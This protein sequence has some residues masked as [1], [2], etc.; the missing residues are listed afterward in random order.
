MSQ[1]QDKKARKEVNLKRA[2]R[3]AVELAVRDERRRILG[4]IHETLADVQKAAERKVLAT[5]HE[6]RLL[7]LR[8]DVSR[9]TL[10]LLLGRIVAN[11]IPETPYVGEVGKE[12]AVGPEATA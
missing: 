11:H 3:R 5:E 2:L 4:L 1:K 8:T 6:Y 10:E 12:G 7:K 9:A